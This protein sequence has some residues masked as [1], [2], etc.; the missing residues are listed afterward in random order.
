MKLPMDSLLLRRFGRL[1]VFAVILV[2]APFLVLPLFGLAW[3]WDKGWLLEWMLS[4]VVLG[5]VAWLLHA[6]A[7]N[8]PIDDHI[9]V[10]L[11]F[12]V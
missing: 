5:T 3:L 11:E 1:R 9:N 10:V 8:D 7:H 12:L 4:M 6:F 2:S